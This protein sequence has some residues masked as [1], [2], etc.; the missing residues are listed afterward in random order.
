[1]ILRK[2]L[3][4]PLDKLSPSPG[5]PLLQRPCSAFPCSSCSWLAW[6][7]CNCAEYGVGRWGKRRMGETV[8]MTRD[9]GSCSLFHR[10]KSILLF[11]RWIIYSL[12][13]LFNSYNIYHGPGARIQILPVNEDS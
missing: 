8:L 1:M 13:H 9:D 2:E 11:T 6:G 4:C 10:E 12:I 3:R 7:P 5:S